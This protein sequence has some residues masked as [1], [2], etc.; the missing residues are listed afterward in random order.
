MNR[1]Y[2][3]LFDD[4]KGGCGTLSLLGNFTDFLPRTA[5]GLTSIGFPSIFPLSYRVT[6]SA[7]LT[8]CSD[9]RNEALAFNVIITTILFTILRPKPIVLFWSLVCI[10]FWHITLF[11][12]PRTNPPDLADAF[13]SFLPALFICYCFWRLAYRHVLPMFATTMPIESAVWF[14]GPF[15][16]MYFIVLH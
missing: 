14:L 7:S 15:W 9:L 2:S 16:G 13:G 4:S 12:Q 5:N 10:G 8:E 3:G 11:S 6:P 1:S